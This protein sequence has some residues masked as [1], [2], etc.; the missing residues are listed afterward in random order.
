MDVG[1]APAKVQVAVGSALALS[2][3]FLS[4]PRDLLLDTVNIQLDVI[5]RFGPKDSDEAVD[6]KTR[7][8][9]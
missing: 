4:A 7:D 8:S 9:L 5:R 3:S 2:Q 1:A 6:R